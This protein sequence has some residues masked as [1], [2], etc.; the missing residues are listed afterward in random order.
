MLTVSVDMKSN[1]S[2]ERRS[3]RRVN[4]VEMGEFKHYCTVCEQHGS[5]AGAECL[6]I[7]GAILINDN[8]N[9]R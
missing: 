9:S 1:S 6:G 3:S 4:D 8:F 7:S 5:Y 2:R